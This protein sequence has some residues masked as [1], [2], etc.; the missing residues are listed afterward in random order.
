[1]R[2]IGLAMLPQLPASFVEGTDWLQRKA[3]LLE[4][5]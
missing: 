2:S 1:M 4:A 3:G 5:T